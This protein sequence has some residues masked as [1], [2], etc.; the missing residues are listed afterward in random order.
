MVTPQHPGQLLLD[1]DYPFIGT[2]CIRSLTMHDLECS[3]TPVHRT[4][5]TRATAASCL[6]ALIVLAT[7]TLSS[8]PAR[9]DAIAISGFA[10]RTPIVGN[11]LAV[12]GPGAVCARAEVGPGLAVDP[13]AG[14][15]EACSD[16]SM[17]GPAGK[18]VPIIGS[19]AT[20]LNGEK[21]EAAFKDRPGG[22]AGGRALE[23]KVQKSD[24]KVG[25]A[26]NNPDPNNPNQVTLSRSAKAQRDATQAFSA[27]NQTVSVD[28][29]GTPDLK[30]GARA[31]VIEV[32]PAAGETKKRRHGFAVGIVNDPIELMRTDPTVSSS[33]LIGWGDGSQGISLQATEPGDFATV[34][35]AIDTDLSGFD[36]VLSM[37]MTID[38]FTASLAE[39]AFEFFVFNPAIGFATAAEFLAGRLL[40]SLSF[41]AAA[42]RLSSSPLIPIFELP[43]PSTG[44][45]ELRV[46]V[47]ALAE[48]VPEPASLLTL[49]FGLGIF[50][51]ARRRPLAARRRTSRLGAKR[52]CG[53]S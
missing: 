44:T 36:N 22:E 47:E 37:A 45:V 41:D 13:A 6:R 31:E 20:K 38:Y 8:S 14:T 49:G 23:Y 29:A 34:Y 1:A 39:V 3:M 17:I 48:T 33:V 16:Q 25:D 32:P 24:D 15:G 18:K 7:L 10:I 35:L 11:V 42:H 9:G 26:I 53:H 19:D 21:E 30:G 2:N 12:K 50:A 51:L 4:V 46:D 28:G 52:R 27:A 43:L 5:A 40:P